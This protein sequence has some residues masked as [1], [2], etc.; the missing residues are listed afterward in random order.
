MVA[1]Q[2]DLRIQAYVGTAGG[3][4]PAP[5]NPTPAVPPAVRGA[6]RPAERTARAKRRAARREK[7]KAG[8][9]APPPEKKKT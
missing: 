6:A 9:K 8:E 7:A 4:E 5:R 3:E 1:W 2:K